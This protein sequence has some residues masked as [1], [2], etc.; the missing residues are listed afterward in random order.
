VTPAYL[1]FSIYRPWVAEE[2]TPVCRSAA[3]A[4]L[5]IADCE[6]V[7][8]TFGFVHGTKAPEECV[9]ALEFLRGWGIPATLHFVGDLATHT[10]SADLRALVAALGLAERVRFF[11]G[12]VSEQTYRDY[13]VGADLG[14]QLRTYGL[15][16]LS[17]GLLDCAAVGLP[18]VTNA[19]LGEAVGV[20]DYVRCIPDAISPLLLAEALADLLD[21]GLAAV[22]PEAARQAFGEPRSFT[23]YAARLCRALGLETVAAAPPLVQAT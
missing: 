19:S 5:G 15:G 8:A 11:E 6:I 20:P 3:R 7:V 18:S 21:A 4:R 17:G 13:L 9:W 22:R 12:Y 14:V 23:H 16:G 10:G 2:L 1:P